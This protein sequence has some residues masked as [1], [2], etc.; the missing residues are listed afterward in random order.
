MPLLTKE[1][2]ESLANFDNSPALSIYMPTN[3]SGKDVLEEKD[4]IQLKS[5]W[6]KVYEK[7]KSLGTSQ[8][9]ID[10]LGKPV[11]ELLEDTNFWRKQSN[12]LALFIANG[13]FEKFIT[14]VEFRPEFF[15]SD[16]F[17]LKP[18]VP[19]LSGDGDFYLLSLQIFGVQFYSANSYEIKKIKT[20]E[21]TPSRLEDRVGYDYEEN[22]RL[23]DTQSPAR[24]MNVSQGVGGVEKDQK[25][26]Y[27]RY[28]RAVDKGL[29]QILKG[30]KAPLVVACQDYLFPIYK[31]ANTYKN[32]FP[33]PVKGNPSDF[34]NEKELHRASVELLQPFFE[35]ERQEKMNQFQ[36]L[37]PERKSADV[38][39]IL[40]AVFAGKVDT[41]FIQDREEIWGNYNENMA[42]V[43]IGDNSENGNIS[44]L[45]LAAIKVIG[46]NGS[47]YILDKE[48]MPDRNSKINAVYRY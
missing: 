47:V 48:F 9:E 37:V 20:E 30:K 4:R 29:H 3:R 15:I 44:L 24:G 32:L 28:F 19:L 35:Q 25:N 6:K 17:H 45:N 27:L 41:L 11:E 2:F 12:G 42:S 38:S 13:K 16:H 22:H 33:K 26:E 39:E 8:D 10:Q 46:Q 31:E 23:R 43:E 36:D 18:L 14:P 40:P 21:L 5:Q 7:L 34:E 1:K